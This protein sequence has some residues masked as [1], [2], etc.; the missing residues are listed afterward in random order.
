[1]MGA[2]PICSTTGGCRDHASTCYS[3]RVGGLLSWV[4]LSDGKALIRTYCLA[5]GAAEVGDDGGAGCRT[6]YLVVEHRKEK[7]MNIILVIIDTLR[8]DYVGASGNEWIQT[9]NLDRLAAESWVF[10]NS[11][12]SSYPTIPHRTDVI[13]GSYGNP[14]HVW[15]PL[16]FDVPTLPEALARLGYC[17]QLIHDTPHLVNGGHSF[18]YPFHAWTFVRGAEV[19]RSWLTGTPSIPD[20]WAR[21]P[22]FDN[23][24]QAPPPPEFPSGEYNAIDAYM[25]TNR[26][27]KSYEDWNCA[28]LFLA[29]QEFLQDNASRTNFFL[30][31]DCFDPHEPWDAPPE[32]LLKYDT[33]P[34]YDGRVDPRVFGP[35]RESTV[36]EAAVRRIR[37]MYAAKV[38]WV[39]RWF[40]LLLD[41]LEDTGLMK[42]TAIIVTS[43]HGTNDGSVNGF[44]KKQ[45]PREG[46]AHTP[47]MVSVPGAGSGASDMIVQPQDLF[48]TVLGIADPCPPSHLDSHDVLTIAREGGS[49]ARRIAIAGAPPDD[50]EILFTAFDGHWCLEVAARLEQCRL[51]HMGGTDDVAD[52]NPQVVRDLREMALNE[53]ERRGADPVI[54]HWLR[55][56]GT[57][58]FPS[59]YKPH[60]FFPIPS[61]YEQYFKRLYHGDT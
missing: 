45:P 48:A 7:R 32:Y 10:S 1:M 47:F 6:P 46:E 40:G 28:R 31:L 2:A 16:P 43:D 42:N 23:Q 57:M 25:P 9:P 50:R 24:P 54:M 29:A 41:A 33:T 51:V 27:R 26:R 39:D 60:R 22:L 37:A 18:D 30:W 35:W 58:S 44:G 53:Y 14:F 21:D 34:G 13:T 19:D 12:T 5:Q 55:T 11:Y 15:M 59:K 56:E 3:T 38:S 36:T 52:A 4:C 17:T 61:G 49:A 8:Y 20:N